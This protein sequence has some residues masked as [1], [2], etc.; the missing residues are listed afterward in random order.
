MNAYIA[1]S[2][3]NLKLTFRDRTVLF[4]NYAFPLIFFFMFAGLF[5][6]ERGGAIVQVLTMVLTIGILGTG[7]F[8]AGMRS[9]Q[10]RE[11]NILRRFKVAPITAVPILI[12]SIVTG[13]V[14][15]LPG[16]ILMVLLSHFF[17]G[18]PFPQ[19]WLSLFAYVSLGVIAFRSI[20]LII[21]SVVNSAQ[22]SII[23][24]QIL[25][26]PMLMLSGATIP[27][28]I[29]PNWLQI[30]AQFIPSTY[31]ITGMQAIL[32]RQ[33]TLWQNIWP[34]CALVLTSV[35]ALF[36][37]SK[38]FRWEKEA[39]LPASSKFWVIGILAPFLLLGLYQAKTH[40]NMAKAKMLI[41]QQRRER[42]FVIRDVRIFVGNG[43][44]IESGGVL[45]KGGKI[46]RV[47]EGSTPDPKELNADVVEGSGKTLI[48]GLIDVH[49]HL[50]GSG[51][52]GETSSAINLDKQI[53]RELAAYLYSGIT[54]VKSVGD[55]LSQMKKDRQLVNF[56]EKMG[57]ELFICGPM[58]TAVGGHGTEYFKSLP[59]NI[60]KAAEAETVR[61]PGSPEEARRQVAE[62]KQEGVDG[63]K[64]ILEAG[65]AGTLFNRMDTAVLKAIADEAHAR[66]LPIVVHTGDAKDVADALSAGADGLEHG[67][68]RDAIPDELFVKM[69]AQGVSYDPTLTVLDA[70]Q[71][72]ISGST[73]P[74][75]RSLVQQVVPASLLAAT[76]AYL[77]SAKVAEMRDRLK[78]MGFSMDRA[79]Q[80]LLKAYQSGV[81]LVTGS[82]AGNPLVWH[83]PTIHRELQL[84]V[85]AGI[86]PAVALQAATYNAAKL[87]RSDDR[88]GLIEKGRDATML[89]IDGNP[90][91]DIKQTESI[92]SVIFK[93]ERVDRPDLFDQ[94]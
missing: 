36:V 72:L 65:Q 86:P 62:L 77:K 67:S 26:F 42:T 34:A 61:T 73:E 11:L 37:S 90:L 29:L 60:R 64:A 8:G 33:E 82:D 57:T 81:I 12:S 1:Q 78:A 21:A 56:G 87:L 30:F 54:A 15:Y 35:L 43:K 38:L 85:D 45:V 24:I 71:D 76:K 22:E 48:P 19:R 31:L 50:S 5:K 80:N 6:A 13:L 39:R 89:L 91:K 51:G 3:I 20:G 28:T 69:K 84:W 75:D 94:E 18:M 93:G 53:P 7:F 46:E 2:V 88:M 66:K 25:Y 9:V 92:R 14:N 41:R 83:G 49:V 70:F 32:G 59:E 16:A 47:F 58:F 79:N 52:L 40:D 63:I 74:L 27:L 55:P 23:L 68:T 10:D 4:F 17:Y 44:V